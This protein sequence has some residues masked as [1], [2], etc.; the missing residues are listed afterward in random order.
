MDFGKYINS[1]LPSLGKDRVLEDI[2]N[3]R[4]ELQDTVIP[5][6]LAATEFFKQHRFQDKSARLGQ[7]LNA[8]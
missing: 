5:P 2:S 8:K 6:Y 7:D 4:E 3:L 1:L